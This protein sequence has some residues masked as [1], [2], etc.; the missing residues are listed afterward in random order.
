MG[1]V[2]SDMR[3]VLVLAYYFPPLGLSGVQRVVGFVKHLPQFGWHPTVITAKPAGYFAYDESLRVEVESTGAEVH[4]T[5]SLDP[6]RFSGC[7]KPIA[8]PAEP[9]RRFL[10]AVSQT[11]ILPDN[12]IGWLPF[13]VR[14]SARMHRKNPF[15][16]ILASAPP[17]SSLWAALRL[18]KRLGIPMVLDFRDDWVGNALRSYPTSLHR[19]YDKRL[20]RR[21]LR[22]ASRVTAINSVIRDSLVERNPGLTDIEVLPHGYDVGLDSGSP[23]KKRGS[24][25]RIV[26]TGIFYD[27]QTPDFFLRALAAIAQEYPKI[28]D[29]ID[30]RFWGLIPRR[31][32]DLV[33]QLGLGKVVR[34]EGYVPHG[35]ALAA[36][37]GADILWLTVGDRPY[38]DGISTSKL[39][40]YMGCRKPILALVP[41]GDV[42]RTLALYKAACVVPPEDVDGIAQAIV[43][44]YHDWKT[45]ALPV[46]DETFVVSRSRTRVTEIL[47]EYLDASLQ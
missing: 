39:S 18:K 22:E 37:Q 21:V 13:A 10:S 33:T 40:E 47:A 4:S 25:M 19:S 28:I 27:A 23:P 44:W 7:K 26:Y 11:I 17:Y 35:E 14:A 16:V 15:D 29:D 20:E 34:Y 5:R 30:V 42:Q 32:L 1:E 43:R 45:K 38:A 8:L 12:K 3:R 9:I 6:T 36:Q 24:K 2:D 41:P 31:S 46:P